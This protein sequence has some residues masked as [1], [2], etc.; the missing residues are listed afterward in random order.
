M[1]ITVVDL[2]A[3][4]PVSVAQFDAQLTSLLSSYNPNLE[5]TAGFFHDNVLHLKAILDAADQE[6]ITLVMQANS[7]LQI[8]TNP[9]LADPTIT[10]N[11]LS[12]YNI[13]PNP[14]SL[15][16]G[17]ITIILSQLAA[18][19]IPAGSIFTING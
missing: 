11:C 17:P 3:L 19:I 15:A 1:G 16:S 7:L 2:N 10:A 14:G 8:S 13:V 18:V 5:L 9:S 4:D 12:N 6:N